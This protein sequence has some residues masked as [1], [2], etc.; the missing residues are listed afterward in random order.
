MSACGYSE[1][2]LCAYVDGEAGSRERDVEH[3][4]EHCGHCRDT[5][6]AWRHSSSALTALVDGGLG[7][8]EPLVAL[9]RIRARIAAA[10]ERSLVARLAA[11]WRDLWVFNRRAVA[12][13][14]VAAGLGMLCAPAVVLWAGRHLQGG[15]SSSSTTFAGVVIESMELGGGKPAIYQGQSGTT[16]LIWVEP[17]GSQSSDTAGPPHA[18]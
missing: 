1:A 3:H 16:T 17:D 14:M 13:V 5:V 4:L 9:S 15:G 18:P 11:G 6:A 2:L 12:G 8:V 10:E 7:E